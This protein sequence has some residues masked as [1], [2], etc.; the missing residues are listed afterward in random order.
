MGF[1]CS[2]GEGEVEQWR[3]S[4]EL[5]S[6]GGL[7]LESDQGEGVRKPV[8]QVRIA[9]SG[10]GPGRTRP[11]CPRGW[12]EDSS[13][14]SGTG[15][16]DDRKPGRQPQK[17]EAPEDLHVPP[18]K[19]QGAPTAHEPGVQ[20]PAWHVSPVVQVEPSQLPIPSGL[21]VQSD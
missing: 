20:A 15:Y 5:R 13:A 11:L 14:R 4:F 9:T 6:R 16:R 1:R 3:R 2:L 10:V 12:A 21:N 7:R 8:V 19:P 18:Q 17:Q